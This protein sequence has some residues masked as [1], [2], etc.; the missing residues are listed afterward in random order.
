MKKSLKKLGHTSLHP[1]SLKD[2]LG[3]R[4]PTAGALEA[5][6]EG[7]DQEGKIGTPALVEAIFDYQATEAKELTF[8]KGDRFHL[9]FL[10]A[11]G[12]AIGQLPNGTQGWFSIEFVQVLEENVTMPAAVEEGGGGN[13]APSIAIGKREK[14]PPSEASSESD[15]HKDETQAPPQQEN[16]ETVAA[17]E[18][19]PEDSGTVASVERSVKLHKSG[20]LSKKKKQLRTPT[21]YDSIENEVLI[22]G[23]LNKKGR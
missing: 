1:G 6:A 11:T 14:L 16:V 3:G 21:D 13:S 18:V 9:L 22:C 12:W 7:E 15:G 2:K 23:W 19:K 17:T 4:P 10:D 8:R 5:A 20:K